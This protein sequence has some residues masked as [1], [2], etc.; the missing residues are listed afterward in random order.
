VRFLPSRYILPILLLVLLAFIFTHPGGLFT[1]DDERDVPYSEFRRTLDPQRSADSPGVKYVE[2]HLDQ[3]KH[4]I[5]AT[6][7]QGSVDVCTAP[8]DPELAETLLAVNP[9][10]KFFV[11]GGR[12]AAVW[13]QLL[14]SLIIPLGLFIF[15]IIMFRQMQAGSGQALSF[16]RSRAKRWS[17]S[18]EHVTFDDVAGI[19]E[20]KEELQEVVEFLKEPEK[21]RALGA[22]IPK[23]TLLTGSPGCGKTLL[24]RAI[25]GEANVPFY[26]ISGSD[27]VE[28]FVGV[29]ASRVRDLFDQAKSN[30]R[31]I[32][33]IDEIDAVGRHRGSG[34]GGGH[35]EREQTLNQLLVE[36]DG[37]DRTSGVLLLA[38]TNRPDV[39]DPAL[40]RPGRFDRRVHVENPDLKGRTEIFDLYVR[41]RPVSGDVEVRAL[42]KRTPGFTGADIEILVNEAAILAARRNKTEI[43]RNDFEDATDRV[44]VG[45]E[46]RSRM[47]T[48]SERRAL[49][50]HEAGHALVSMQLPGADPLHKVSITARG[51]ALGFTLQVPDQDRHMFAKQHLLDKI[52]CILAGR[53]AEE[54]ALGDRYSGAAN[55]LEQVT[56]IARAMVCQFGM[57]DEL[58]PI[59]IGRGD[60]QVF[61]GKELV[62]ER[63]VSDGTAR[64]IDTETRRIAREQHDRATSIILAHRA[65]LDAVVEALLEE[66]TLHAEDLVA[67]VH[68]VEGPDAEANVAGTAG[69]SKAGRETELPS[70]GDADS[71]WDSE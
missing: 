11:E 5:K 10:V 36:M 2:V 12:S 28:M 1:D 41:E 48:D 65:L 17:D 32:V 61:L 20:A 69:H 60:R 68:K 6:T 9:D 62:Q 30:E 26:Y 38:A 50:Y 22:R 58:G 43:D 71:L 55:D 33:F 18:F 67:L 8:M 53:A 40:L 64:T 31:C 56:E 46:R 13:V 7:D 15:I 57:S 42:A 16:G 51:P 14:S 70:P 39:L 66:E 54:T 59:A 3:T 25:A 24:A 37:F 44:Q 52:C 63:R 34:L 4:K 49:A 21:F 47:L 35:D 45:L 29:G 19:E 27:F 23:G